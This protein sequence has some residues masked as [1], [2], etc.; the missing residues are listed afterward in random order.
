MIG[1]MIFPSQKLP[2]FK[3][4]KN[5]SF[6]ESVVCPTIFVSQQISLH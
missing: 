3:G 6:R 4:E 5:V 1:E 2:I